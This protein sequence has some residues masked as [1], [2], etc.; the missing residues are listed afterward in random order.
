MHRLGRHPLCS[1]S[2]VERPQI[3]VCLKEGH[4]TYRF[5]GSFNGKHTLPEK[6]VELTD[7]KNPSL[8]IS[9]CVD[10]FREELGT[11]RKEEF[12]KELSAKSRQLT[13]APR[14]M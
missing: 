7:E 9:D 2:H 5:T 3:T 8:V 11:K 10:L 6:A 13:Q 14:R 4:A 12:K 1:C